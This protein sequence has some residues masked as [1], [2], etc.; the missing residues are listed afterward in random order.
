MV[1][2]IRF[3]TRSR[4]RDQEGDRIRL[5]SVRDAATAARDSAIKE[6]EGL[7]SR[8]AE[9]YDR[10]VVIMDTSGEY[11]ERSPEDENEINSASREA[12][13]A[14]QRMRDIGRTIEIFD[15]ILLKLDDAERAGDRSADPVTAEPNGGS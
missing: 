4:L 2:G 5:Q 14:E 12:A 8:I 15:E 10:A 7:R 6:R 13:S 9:W 11:G 3:R 1:L